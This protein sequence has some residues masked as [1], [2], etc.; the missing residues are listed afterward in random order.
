MTHLGVTRTP[1]SLTAWFRRRATAIA[2]LGVLAVLFVGMYHVGFNILRLQVGKDPFQVSVELAQAGGLYPRSEVTYR[3]T[4]V[5]RVEEI[6]LR[7]GGVIAELALDEGTNIPADTDAVITNL[8]AA[9]EQFLDLRPRSTSKPYLGPNSVIPVE[10]TQ[11]PVAVAKLIRDVAVLLDQIDSEAL[12]TVVDEL[13]LALQSTG[14][15]LGRLID[16]ADHLLA[17]LQETLPNTLNVL[18]NGRTDLDT[19]NELTPEF[20]EFNASLRKLSKQLKSADPSLRGLFDGGPSSVRELNSFVETLTTPISAVLA[21]LVTPGNLI[22]A[23]LPALNALLIAFPQATGALA[24]TVRNG[25]FGVYLHLT[26]NGVCEYTDKR[27]LPI[28]PTRVAPRLDRVCTSKAPGVGAR[29]AQNAPRVKPSGP[30]APGA[31]DRETA[32]PA[33]TVASYDPSAPYIRLPDGTRMAPSLVGGGA[34]RAM[35][36]S[37]MELLLALLRS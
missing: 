16:R 31:S 33:A 36:A 21:N 2:N 34:G 23:R 26:N 22:T 20:A 18:R 9:G 27:R 28:D 35:G 3:G 15:A 19:A 10:R 7:P 4:V 25:N 8:S 12:T 1:G 13:A 24:T 17:G 11:A 6:R 14:P 37:W 32:P 5:G 29:G 30:G